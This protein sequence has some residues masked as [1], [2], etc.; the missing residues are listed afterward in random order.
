MASKPT[1]VAP[2]AATARI[3]TYLAGLPADQGSAL[4]ALRERIAGAAPEAVEA[5]S[6]G[7]PAFRYRGRPL[8]SYLAAKAHCSFFPMS[9]AV[10][11]AYRADLAGYDTAKGTIRFTPDHRLPDELVEAIVRARLAELDAVGKAPKG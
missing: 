8:V 10:V 6:Y 1:P 3:D 2:D 7:A 5:I 11:E 4:Q 9:P